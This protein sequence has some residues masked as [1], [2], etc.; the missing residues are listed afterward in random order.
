MEDLEKLAKCKRGDMVYV[1]RYNYG[2][3]E[4]HHVE[5]ITVKRADTKKKKI[6]SVDI[7]TTFDGKNYS[8][9]YKNL[10]FSVS[11]SGAGDIYVTYD[12][13]LEY[14]KDNIEWMIYKAENYDYV[15]NEFDAIEW[16]YRLDHIVTVDDKS[17]YKEFEKRFKNVWNEYHNIKPKKK[18][19]KKTE[20]IMAPNVK[21]EIGGQYNATEEIERYVGGHSFINDDEEIEMEVSQEEYLEFCSDCWTRRTRELSSDAIREICHFYTKK[22]I[23]F[24]VEGDCS[25]GESDTE[26]YMQVK[27]VHY[28][29]D[30]AKFFIHSNTRICV[31]EGEVF[32]NV[33]CDLCEQLPLANNDEFIKTKDSKL[34]LT[35]AEIKNILEIALKIVSNAK[36][37]YTQLLNSR[38]V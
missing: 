20:T 22:W 14:V 32:P 13:A 10:N 3:I 2:A 9:S 35:D 31:N 4:R 28:D 15:G 1:P 21:V 24:I 6:Q 37:R 25:L 7:S 27:S 30:E 33:V 5:S 12:D 29:E 34:L 8:F 11:C 17:Y 16:Q 38:G 26:F 19:K 18:N 23:K 36:N